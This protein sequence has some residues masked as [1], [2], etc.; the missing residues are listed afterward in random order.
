MTGNLP[1][2]SWEEINQYDGNLT[3]YKSK[4]KKAKLSNACIN[5]IETLMAKNPKHRPT[6]VKAM[7]HEWLTGGKAS[8]EDLG[9]EHR[10][11][12]KEYDEVNK[13]AKIVAKGNLNE[14]DKDELGLL[15]SRVQNKNDVH[16]FLKHYEASMR[17]DNNQH[18]YDKSY[19]DIRTMHVLASI[20]GGGNK[21]SKHNGHHHQNI[22]QQHQQQKHPNNGASYNNKMR[23]K[24][25]KPSFNEQ[26]Q[27]YDENIV[28]Q[29]LQM[30]VGSRNACIRA[31]LSVGNMS[32]HMAAEWL[33]RHMGNP[34]INDPIE[35]LE[36][37]KKREN[38]IVSNDNI[39]PEDEEVENNV[40]NDDIA[41]PANG[42][43]NEFNNDDDGDG[44][45]D[46]P[47]DINY[48]DSDNDVINND[49]NNN[50][51]YNNYNNNNNIQING[52]NNKMNMN[53]NM[54]G[55]HHHHNYN[56][57]NNGYNNNN[58]N[59]GYSVNSQYD[60]N[61]KPSNVKRYSKKDI[62]RAN[63]K[64][65][66]IFIGDNMHSQSQQNNINGH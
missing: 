59:N 36:E 43:D 45:N 50:N 57:N 24:N 10:A 54:N 51:G 25:N 47:D 7:K 1:F 60:S 23:A 58:N 49:Y 29:L 41:A 62:D 44:K 19:V 4:G 52:G 31:T 55:N 42:Y 27:I 38:K 14:L 6:A 65:L 39:I 56:Y 22:P 5:F 34:K 28:K 35:F 13:V 18:Q 21:K 53:M 33:F 64:V 66:D 46:A 48:N 61:I 17:P 11:N 2:I 26:K 16:K 3:F 30:G 9:D 12:V 20:R 8:D 37:T 32:V 63:D 40:N 15:S